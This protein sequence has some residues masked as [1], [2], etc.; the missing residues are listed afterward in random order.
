MISKMLPIA[1]T[2][3][4]VTSAQADVVLYT[5]R[6]TARMQV[7]ADMYVKAGGEKIQIVEAAYPDLLAKLKSEGTA[8][9]A[10]LIFV[11]DGVYLTE[12]ANL[13]YLSA[14]NSDYINQNVPA[15]LKDNQNRWVFI[16]HRIL[17][18][19]YESSVDVSS[20]NSYAD[21]ANPELAGTI[22]VR[23]SKSSYTEGLVASLVAN[24]GYSEAKRIVDGILK[25]RPQPSSYPKDTAI[26]NAIATGDCVL[27]LSNSYYLGTMMNDQ[28]TIPIKIKTLEMNGQG[29]HANGYGAGV[30][31][32]SKQKDKATKFLEFLISDEVQNYLSSQNFDYPVK[33]GLSPVDI[34]K[35]FGPVKIDTTNWSLIGDYVDEARKL[36]KELN[37][38]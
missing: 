15:P 13:G 29:V 17:T 5:D 31:T 32:N 16:T 27:G 26:L 35:K 10:D 12:L 3:F 7:V 11:K 21:L 19:V 14:F 24:Y 36:F 9:S 30:A 23:T 1:I 8:S 28:P 6:P 38:D 34:V 2:L 20:I 25:N 37:F 33:T 22:C 18:L 4:F